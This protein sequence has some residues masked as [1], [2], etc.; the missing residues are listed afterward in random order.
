MRHEKPIALHYNLDRDYFSI[1]ICR[2]NL[3]IYD[4]ISIYTFIHLY[5]LYLFFLF[6]FIFNSQENNFGNLVAVVIK[7]KNGCDMSKNS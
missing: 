2:Y 7:W 4:F 3:Y 1:Y 5:L 6:I